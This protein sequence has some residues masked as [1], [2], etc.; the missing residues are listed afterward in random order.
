MAW[1]IETYRDARGNLPVDD[2]IRSLPLKG[3]GRVY[4]TL[5]LLKEFGLQLSMPYTRPL[6]GK[7]WE[8]RI[9]SGRSAY[10][11]LYFAFTGQRFVLL[12]G[13]R[14]KSR[15]TPQREFQIAERRMADYVTR[16]KG[17]E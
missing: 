14:K 17:R 8:L 13:F 1:I 11:I 12:H 6:R 5:E 3:R 4:W 2:F 10:R 15:K 7:L 9:R 16:A